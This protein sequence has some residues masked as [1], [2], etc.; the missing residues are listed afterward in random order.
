MTQKEKKKKI[1][2]GIVLRRA[3]ESAPLPSLVNSFPGLAFN[4]GALN[5]LFINM[6]AEFPCLIC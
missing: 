2:L 3:D 4:S 5:F 6:L 1:A